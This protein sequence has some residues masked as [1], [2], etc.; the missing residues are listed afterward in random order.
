MNDD[1]AANDNALDDHD[2]HA[3]GLLDT[4]PMIPVE[5]EVPPPIEERH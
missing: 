5:E 3:V 4:L 1:G 2:A